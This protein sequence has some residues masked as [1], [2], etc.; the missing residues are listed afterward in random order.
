[1]SRHTLPNCN[2]PLDKKKDH[3]ILNSNIMD[4]DLAP[5]AIN[6]ALKN[7][8]QEAININLAIIKQDKYNT[9]ALN[10]L[11]FSYLQQGLS[12]KARICY[13]QVVNI[14]PYNEIAK[15]NLAKI[16]TL[17]GK[18]IPHS[19][20]ENNINSNIG[21]F[22]E[23][24]GKTKC[25]N[26]IKIATPNTISL[27]RP[28]EIVKLVPKRHSVIV[29]NPISTYI[30]ALP[31]DIG[32]KLAKRI[33]AGNRYEACIKSAD[34]K[35]LVIFIRELYRAKRFKDQPTFPTATSQDYYSFVRD[36]LVPSDERL[37]D[38]QDEENPL[39][40]KEEEE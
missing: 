34:K 14:D 13:Q 36:P 21:L 28:S 10:R 18:V 19:N 11:A 25:V 22:I 38:Q 32:H 20:N 5:K 30:G 7:N 3:R 16:K 8:W 23:E 1:M 12:K 33:K 6:A 24:P 40:E 31:D 35:S 15:K 27:L 2:I 17:K 4:N 9:E 39:E 37:T 29:E 26:L